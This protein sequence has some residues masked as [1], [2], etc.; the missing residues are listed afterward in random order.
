MELITT[1]LQ[2]NDSLQEICH[3]LLS[4]LCGYITGLRQHLYSFKQMPALW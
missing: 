2:V 1:D 3:Q 4:P